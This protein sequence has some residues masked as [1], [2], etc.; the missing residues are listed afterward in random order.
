MCA[1]LLGIINF[2]DTD[3]PVALYHLCFIVLRS[4]FLFFYHF[5]VRALSVLCLCSPVLLP[6]SVLNRAFFRVQAPT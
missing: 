5:V 3:T 2:K 1:Y 4:C 6:L